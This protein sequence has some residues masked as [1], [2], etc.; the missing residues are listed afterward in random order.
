MYDLYK[1]VKINLISFIMSVSQTR[2]G[3]IYK[4]QLLKLKRV[5]VFS[6]H[7]THEPEPIKSKQPNK[8]VQI[9]ELFGVEPNLTCT[10]PMTF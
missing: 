4:I 2:Q 5:R 6:V 10:N 3:T 7:V 1:F 9:Q 8:L